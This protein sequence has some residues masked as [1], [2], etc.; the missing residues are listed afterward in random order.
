MTHKQKNTSRQF[1]FALLLVIFCLMADNL[2]AQK[3][4]TQDANGNYIEV[5]N[6]RE[7]ETPK[8]TGK[9]YQTS[10]GDIFPIYVSKNGK[11]FIVRTSKE[12]GKEY[13]QYLNIEGK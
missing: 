8:P 6:E 11:Y 1:I 5:K 9:T 10:K 13:K 4:V 7:K 2:F 3:R 12:S